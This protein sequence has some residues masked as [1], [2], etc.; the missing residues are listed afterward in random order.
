MRISILFCL[1]F[2]FILKINAQPI[3]E[4]LFVL[5]LYMVVKPQ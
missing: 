3:E 4:T 2:V 5:G 1:L